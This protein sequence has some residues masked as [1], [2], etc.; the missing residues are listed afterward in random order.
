M[1]MNEKSTIYWTFDDI[2]DDFNIKSNER[3][4]T[5]I[6]TDI[7]LTTMNS[8]ML[9]IL[10]MTFTFD[11]LI[12]RTKKIHSYE[13]KLLKKRS[14]VTIL[15]YSQ[16]YSQSI[17]DFILDSILNLFLTLFLIYSQFYSQFYSQS[18][19]DSILDLFLTLFSTLYSRFILDFILNLDYL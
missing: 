16:L 11:I 9:R 10:L 4:M 13:H 5:T 7:T 2:E 17:L 18:I 14:N 6:L 1:R 19:L 15:I 12:K 8:W 3:T